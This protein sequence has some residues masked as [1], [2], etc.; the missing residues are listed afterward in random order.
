MIFA[1]NSHSLIKPA[2]GGDL[3][4]LESSTRYCPSQWALRAVD[5]VLRY[6]SLV[7]NA[8][9]LDVSGSIA[10]KQ[11]GRIKSQLGCVIFQRTSVGLALTSFRV[12]FCAQLTTNFQ[13]L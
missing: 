4:N 12:K 5:R 2:V 1:T 8:E 10:S 7:K 3:K 13:E 11:I 9:E 6:D